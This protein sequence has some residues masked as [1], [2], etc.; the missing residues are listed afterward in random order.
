M[1]SD[2]FRSGGIGH[3]GYNLKSR[4]TSEVPL[5][6]TMTSGQV[7]NGFE[8]KNSLGTTIFSV[9]PVGNVSYTGSETITDALTVTG[10]T[11]LLSSLSVTGTST[12]GAIIVNSTSTFNG[13]NTFNALATF[14][15][16]I[17]FDVNTSLT[18]E[19]YQI[20]RNLLSALQ[21]NVPSTKQLQL[22]VGDVVKMSIEANSVSIQPSTVFGDSV[23][24]N[25]GLT[26]GAIKTIGNIQL[27][28]GATVVANNYSIGRDADATN[29]LHFNVPT[30]ANMEFSI[31]DT[32][33]MVLTAAGNL[34]IGSTTVNGPAAIEVSGAVMFGAGLLGTFSINSASGERDTAGALYGSRSSDLYI[35]ASTNAAFNGKVAI[36]YQTVS[37][38]LSAVEITGSTTNRVGN[39]LLMKGGGDVTIGG[40]MK[41]SP[42]ERLPEAPTAGTPTA[43]GAVNDGTHSYKITFVTPSGESLP[44]AKSNVITTSGGNNT[45]GLTAIPKGGGRCTARKIYRTDAGD[46]GSWKLI[47]TISDNSTTTYSDTSADAGGAA[48]PTVNTTANAFVSTVVD[49]ATTT[50]YTHDTTAALTTAGALL[51]SWRNNGTQ[52]SFIGLDGSLGT[53]SF[54]L[55]V[56]PSI[57]AA[58]DFTPTSSNVYVTGAT[59]INRIA[60]PTF[61]TT[62][63]TILTLTFASNPLIKY[64]QATGGGFNAIKLAGSADYASAAGGTLSLSWDTVNSVWVEVGR[65]AL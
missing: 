12:L 10:A 63:S 2:T 34:L 58:N 13:V 50:A 35:M 9:S 11:N 29:Q 49:S 48:A 17:Q 39:L 8:I 46:A 24:V 56:Q 18:A 41:I 57:A 16:L 5:I 33:K 40:T 62:H 20:G 19:Q 51:A 3:G 23:V 60:P 44:S 27:T 61:S 38:P 26:S 36:T 37:T 1:F 7:A 42:Q 65:M 28:S 21:L 59:Q 52:K 22:S 14:N 25:G 31:N 54:S 53:S 55:I 47:A 4:T 15:G 6:L 30:G 43:G 32:G 45:V 64:N